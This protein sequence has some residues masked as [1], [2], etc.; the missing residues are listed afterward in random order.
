MTVMDENDP[1]IHRL[2]RFASHEPPAGMFD[3]RAVPLE[4]ARL[5]RT[6][7]FAAGGALVCLALIG[8]ATLT[9]AALRDDDPGLRTPDPAPAATTPVMPSTP[10]TTPEDPFPDD[11][12]KGP[13]PFAGQDPGPPAGGSVADDPVAE[14]QAESD[15]FEAD[16]A[17][18]PDDEDADAAGAVPVDPFPDDPCKGPPSFAGQDPG[19]PPAGPGSEDQP[20]ERQAESDQWEEIKAACNGEGI[21]PDPGAGGLQLDGLPSQAQPS[22]PGFGSTERGP[23]PGVPGDEDAGGP[24]PTPSVGPPPVAGP[25]ADAPPAGVPPTVT[26]PPQ[27]GT[28]PTVTLPPQAGTPPA[29]PPPDAGPPSS[30]GPPPDAGPPPATG[31]PPGVGGP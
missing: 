21:E 13:P 20:A 31:P 14:R 12:C 18:C 28:P 25:P 19:P 15:E 26:L 3:P 29:G 5:E 24:T 22:T 9:V 23:P 1:V 6:R 30:V 16:K 7:R 27:A 11:P 4:P 8:G 10:A 2:R 17:A